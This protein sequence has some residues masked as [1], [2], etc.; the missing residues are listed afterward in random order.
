MWHQ[1][2]WAQGLSALKSPSFGNAPHPPQGPTGRA[3]R[4]S[5]E[6]GRRK[7]GWGL[8]SC[9]FCADLSI[10]LSAGRNNS[11]GSSPKEGKEKEIKPPTQY[12]D[13]H[14]RPHTSG[15]LLMCTM[16]PLSKIAPYI[17]KSLSQKGLFPSV[18]ASKAVPRTG[19]TTEAL[20]FA[21][22]SLIQEPASLIQSHPLPCL[23]LCGKGDT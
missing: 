3:G 20:T 4:D 6:R 17:N 16:C 9:R 15:Q 5:W 10:D 1:G 14:L 22:L 19:D 13:A 21:P 2:I 7:Q 12:E 11:P 23:Q 8:V 18:E